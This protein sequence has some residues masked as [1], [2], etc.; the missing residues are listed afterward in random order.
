[1]TIGNNPINIKSS[2]QFTKG[3]IPTGEVPMNLY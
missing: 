2:V 3:I 1:M